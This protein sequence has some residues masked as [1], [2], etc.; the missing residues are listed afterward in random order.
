MLN[1]L[2]F[3]LMVMP[4]QTGDAATAK[5]TTA[6]PATQDIQPIEISIRLGPMLGPRFGYTAGLDAELNNLSIGPGWSTRFDGELFW[7]PRTGALFSRVN[8]VFSASI[9]QV[10]SFH[11]TREHRWY[12]GGGI[13][14]YGAPVFTQTDDYG[15]P[16]LGNF[17]TNEVL[18]GG[19][20]FLGTQ[21][22]SFSSLELGMHMVESSRP[23]L[24]LQAR[25]TL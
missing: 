23:L 20:L 4:A 19:K 8:T 25:L 21:F 15:N 7:I 12:V 18:F 24:T 3:A 14:G 10:Y 5:A 17:Y 13:G 22:N 11:R 6:K 9:N 16:V 2:M 1:I